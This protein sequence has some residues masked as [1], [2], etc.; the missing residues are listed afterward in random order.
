MVERFFRLKENQTTFRTEVL[1]GVTTF[2]TMAYILFVQPAV[3]SQD[4]AGNPTG[5]SPQ[6]VLFATCVAGFLGCVLM[7]LL[8][9]LA[10]PR[11][12]AGDDGE[13]AR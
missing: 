3:L 9:K 1:A 6:A 7:G 11:H 8:V 5:L 4:F 13:D 2:M 12:L 10:W